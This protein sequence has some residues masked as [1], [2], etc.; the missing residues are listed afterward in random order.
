VIAW[1]A[2]VVEQLRRLIRVEQLRRGDR[3]PTERELAIRLGV[4]RM[5]VRAA[6]RVLK[7]TGQIEIRVGA[8][9]GTFVGNPSSHQ[10]STGLAD[11][12]RLARLTA[13]EITEARQ[14]VELGI[15][16]LAVARATEQDIAELRHLIEQHLVAQRR[17]RYTM[18]LSAD[19]HIRVAACTHNVAIESVVRSFH[20]P[21]L[22][23]LREAQAAAPAM[24]RRG[25]SDHRDFVE[26]LA[27][28]DGYR[29][30]EIMSAHLR[31][32]ATRLARWA[33]EPASAPR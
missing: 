5:T 14:L 21:L 16:E 25:P 1:S 24:G 30:Q 23:S 26:A 12:V 7:A 8:G 13:S 4:S 19:F 29:A 31:R 33:T 9:G 15:I 32:T 27:A 6:L 18:S 2:E 20:N 3:L 28:R 17:G 11:L 10:L 22:M